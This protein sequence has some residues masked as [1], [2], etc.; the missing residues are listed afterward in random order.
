M[1][2]SPIAPTTWNTEESKKAKLFVPQSYDPYQNQDAPR[3]C[4]VDFDKTHNVLVLIAEDTQETLDIID[5]ADV[6]GAS[7]EISFLDSPNNNQEPRA[8][9]AFRNDEQTSSS[10]ASVSKGGIFEPLLRKDNNDKI[11]TV[12]SNE[13]KSPIP[14]DTQAT[15]VLNIYVYPRKDPS[16][17]SIITCAGN[18]GKCQPVK[19]FPRETSNENHPQKLLE[20]YPHHRRFQ[21]APAEDFAF[22]T[23]LVKEIRKLARP[24]HISST[25]ERLLILINPFAGRKKGFEVY[26]TIVVPML[27]EAGIDHDYMLTTY[28]GQAMELMAQRDTQEHGIDDIAKYDGLVA[29][30]GDG[31]V[32]EIMQG[33]K[34]RSDCDAVLKKIKLGHIGAGT[35][36]GLSASLAH[37]SQVSFIFHLFA[38]MMR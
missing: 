18:Q 27:E 29:I 16:S 7:V 6:I 24:N 9:A 5:P 1:S 34:K 37:A 13:P 2:V 36:N 19:E 38:L 33:I 31:S 28:A 35:S 10:V 11:F 23:A 15:A 17:Q 8:T 25:P 4:Y 12:V 32:Y 30:G 26:N 14:S 3:L 21:V 22:I 20:R